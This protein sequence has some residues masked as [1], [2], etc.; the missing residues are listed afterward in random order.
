MRVHL[1]DWRYP[2]RPDWPRCGSYSVA[3]VPLTDDLAKATCGHCIKA[4]KALQG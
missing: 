2:T 1:R 4:Y 3:G